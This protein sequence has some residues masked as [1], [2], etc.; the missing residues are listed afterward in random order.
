MSLAVPTVCGL[1]TSCKSQS[2]NLKMASTDDP[3]GGSAAPPADLSLDNLE[4]LNAVRNEKY[5]V[6]ER[7]VTP[8]VKAASYN[9]FY[10]FTNEKERVKD[11]A[12]SLTTHPWQI[13][14][15]GL[16]KRPKV[17][18]IDDILGRFELEERLYRFRCV[19]TWAM[20][21]PWI[22]IPLS[23]VIAWLEPDNRATHI[24]FMSL[25]RPGEMPG[26]E[27]QPWY[28]W[29]YYEGL[30][31]DEAMNELPLLVVGM[32]G[33]VLPNQ[34][35]APVR[36]ITPWKYGYKSPKSIVK[37]EF[38]DNEPGTFWS[39][40]QPEEYPFLSNVDPETPHPRWSQATETLI[41][42]GDKIKTLPYNGYGNW[43]G[44]LYV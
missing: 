39:D 10:E 18:D 36:I 41:D 27:A 4:I 11:L 13:E 14:V 17:I 32:Y 31:M 22:G 16:V 43:V 5:T 9:N 33:R 3:S 40:Q 7:P 23:K 42:N 44:K 20:T 6:T 15:G 29:P 25:N 24:R 1:K 12:A 26:I 30:R 38:L 21:V 2:N 19:E 35:G 8:F 34:N 28:P 37:I